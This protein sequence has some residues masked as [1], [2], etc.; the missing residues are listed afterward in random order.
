MVFYTFPTDENLLIPKIIT[1]QNSWAYQKI[2]KSTNV[3]GLLHSPT[4]M[5]RTKGEES[6]I[7]T[8]PKDR[9]LNVPGCIILV[10]EREIR[11]FVEQKIDVLPMSKTKLEGKD[12]C[13]FECMSARILNANKERVREGVALLM[14]GSETVWNGV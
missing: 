8:K 9:S 1:L 5:R 3:M 13:I 2:I 11:N 14:S 6:N 7:F 4:K 10:G 12:E